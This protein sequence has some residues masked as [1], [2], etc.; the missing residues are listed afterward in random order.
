MVLKPHT[1]VYPGN[2]DK[3]TDNK[4]KMCSSRLSQV[5]YKDNLQKITNKH[6]IFNRQK[7]IRRKHSW[8]ADTT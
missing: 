1:Y 6:N 5:Q 4:L 2:T 3:N 7:E 8:E